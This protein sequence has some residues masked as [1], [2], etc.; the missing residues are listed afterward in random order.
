MKEDKTLENN[1]QAQIEAFREGY[2]ENSAGKAGLPKYSN[3]YG[4]RQSIKE[5]DPYEMA[6]RQM[7]ADYATSI[8]D[9][10][11]R[12]Q[13]MSQRY[14]P[15][16]ARQ[17]RI[18]KVMAIGK[19]LGALGQLAGGG[20]GPVIRDKDPYQINAWNRLQQLQNEQ[21]VYGRQ[22][23]AEERQAIANMQSGLSR[24]RYEGAR[25]KMQNQYRIAEMQEKSRLAQETEKQKQQNKIT[26]KQMDIEA[27]KELEGIKNKYKLM[28][29]A[30]THINRLDAYAA[31][32]GYDA[33][34]VYQRGLW[35]EYLKGVTSA[36]TDKD[37]NILTSTT[38]FS[39]QRPGRPSG[40]TAIRSNSKA[41]SN[42]PTFSD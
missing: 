25:Q 32:Y 9:I 23:D 4:P 15:D 16:I 12:R 41:Q 33:D 37:G 40:G 24:L 28:S 3:D 29:I 14:Q 17:Q 42:E 13:A 34:L 11:K 21:M 1:P 7:R 35:N 18:M 30:Q 2:A 38:A 20:R 10:R 5:D 27:R 39:G 19:L 31:K 22:L 6:G 36:K 26:L 8:A